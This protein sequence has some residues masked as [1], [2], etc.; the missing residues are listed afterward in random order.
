MTSSSIDNITKPT[1]KFQVLMLLF[2]VFPLFHLAI[3]IS[4]VFIPV[5]WQIQC[6]VAISTLYLLPPL[7]ARFILMIF[8]FDSTHIH[9]NSSCFLA[10]WALANLQ[11]IFVRFGFL[12]EFLRLIPGVY[13]AWLRLWGA[14]I[15]KLTYWAPG[16]II[17]DRS[18]LNIGNNV[19]FGAGVRLNS[20]VIS[21]DEKEGGQLLLSDIVIGDH[22]LIG[23]YSLLTAG[24]Q[25]CENE[26]T[27][28][29]FISPPFS[30]WRK[31]KR[32]RNQTTNSIDGH[33]VV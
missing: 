12:E 5:S 11:T 8:P 2:N 28:A 15:G 24:T 31:G 20:H 13:S 1:L 19:I 27:R 3:C 10:W 29:F 4:I 21:E 26:K 7:L 25:I 23:G 30:L 17:L 14:R 6:L 22:C 33:D 18:F 9:T 16:T 32:V